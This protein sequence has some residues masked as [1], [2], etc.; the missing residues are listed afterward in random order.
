MTNCI[1]TEVALVEKNVFVNT[2]AQV[3]PSNLVERERPMETREGHQ[4][5]KEETGVFL[6]NPGQPR[7]KLANSRLF[8]HRLSTAIFS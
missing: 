2:F 1:L 4:R 8:G 5:F 3:P 7:T 6:H